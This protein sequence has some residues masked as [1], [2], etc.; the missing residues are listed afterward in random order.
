MRHANKVTVT[1]RGFGATTLVS[2]ISSSTTHL[3]GCLRP[4]PTDSLPVLA[5]I[6][7]VNLLQRKAAITLGYWAKELNHLFSAKMLNCG[8]NPNANERSSI[9]AAWCLP[10]IFYYK[11]F[12]QQFCRTFN[13]YQILYSNAP[14]NNSLKL[15]YVIYFTNAFV[16][17]YILIVIFK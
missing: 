6:E 8:V 11:P 13:Y 10:Y 1:L 12:H 16:E 2:L 15:Q 7:P 5:G 4:T 17:I 14:A 3:T 9:C